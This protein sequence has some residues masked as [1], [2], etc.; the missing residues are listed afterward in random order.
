MRSQVFEAKK[1]FKK[2]ILAKK[3][4][5][6]KTL[7]DELQNKQQMRNSKEY[8]KLFRKI[9]PKNKSDPRQPSINEFHDYFEKLSSSNRPQDT[10]PPCEE[11]GP[12]DFTITIKELTNA[13]GRLKLGKA[14]GMDIACNEMI[15]P[16]V[17]THPKLVLKLFNSILDSG[18]IVPSW[19]TGLIVPIH[20]DGS[21]MDPGNYR[22]IIHLCLV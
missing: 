21:K 5:H 14:H 19:I 8:W 10:P 1:N 11:S 2:I 7:V 6:R 17:H 22:G 12:L 13:A 18:E 15:I 4:R 16:L 3:R 9:S 20:K